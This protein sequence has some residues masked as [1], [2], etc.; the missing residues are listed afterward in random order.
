[1]V[2]DGLGD[3]DNALEAE[4]QPE[5]GGAENPQAAADA[6]ANG[7]AP[8]D[9]EPG[10]ISPPPDEISDRHEF[11]L[12]QVGAGESHAEA[13][14]V[15]DGDVQTTLGTLND[16]IGNALRGDTNQP[17]VGGKPGP[18]NAV[19][20]NS[21]SA[22]GRPLVNPLD[23]GLGTEPEA[24]AESQDLTPEDEASPA[25]QPADGAPLSGWLGEGLD[26]T[27]ESQGEDHG[28]QERDPEIETPTSP[29]PIDDVFG[30]V[31]ISDAAGKLGAVDSDTSESESF[32]DATT[33]V[34]VDPSDTSG[35]SATTGKR[36][37]GLAPLDRVDADGFSYM[38]DEIP[39]RQNRFAQTLDL[40]GYPKFSS[41]DSY[42]PYPGDVEPN[43]E[44][45]IVSASGIR[46]V[47]DRVDDGA[48]GT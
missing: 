24:T 33:M 12:E 28:E 11:E 15:P 5:L 18:H 2:G 4:L 13:D 8:V 43:E 26:T 14:A 46:R 42:L 3:I 29:G 39:S 35:H 38:A 23:G 22:A 37:V 30:Q 20:A 36:G 16:V 32:A 34:H 17:E 48:D 45:I 19:E 9:S 7:E 21:Q 1:V 40:I 47:G 44:D 10:A 27:P 6:A 31:L 25:S 41:G